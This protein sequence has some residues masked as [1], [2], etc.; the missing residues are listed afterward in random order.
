M[1]FVNTIVYPPV[2]VNPCSCEVCTVVLRKI[3]Q[4]DGVKRYGGE[5]EFAYVCCDGSPYM[6]FSSIILSPFV[7]SVCGKDVIGSESSV[8]HKKGHNASC[9]M[10]MEF[11]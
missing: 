8:G 1:T 2:F 10:Q 11:D 6:L 3:G 7:C 5:R 9:E 4:Y